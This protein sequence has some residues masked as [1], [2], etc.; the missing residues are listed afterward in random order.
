MSPLRVPID[1]AAILMLAVV[2]TACHPRKEPGA[3]PPPAR[4]SRTLPPTGTPSVEWARIHCEI[5]GSIV[6]ADDGT[7]A[8]NIAVIAFYDADEPM[9]G[10]PIRSFAGPFLTDAQGRFIVPPGSAAKRKIRNQP[11]DDLLG[12]LLVIHPTL[13]AVALSMSTS[14]YPPEAPFANLELVQYRNGEGCGDIRSSY[15]KEIDHLPADLRRIAWN[16]VDPSLRP[17]RK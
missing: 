16:C 1:L 11:N 13:G 17:V 15:V 14:E 3:V 6:F 12:T 4:R 5:R 2:T 10:G 7:P 9:T 8:P